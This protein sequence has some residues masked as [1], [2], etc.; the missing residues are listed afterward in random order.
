MRRKGDLPKLLQVDTFADWAETR[1]KYGF[2]ATYPLAFLITDFLVE[3][4]SFSAVTA[5][6]RLFEKSED[7]AANFKLALGEE[8]DEF[9]RALQPH[10]DQLLGEGGKRK[11]PLPQLGTE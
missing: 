6:F 4:H 7:H 10:L 9:D 8:L 1:K 11:N 3:R 2:D 5:Y